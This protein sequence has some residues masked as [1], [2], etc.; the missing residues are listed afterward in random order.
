MRIT[1]AGY[2]FFGLF[3]KTGKLTC[4]KKLCPCNKLTLLKLCLGRF[5]KW[6]NRARFSFHKRIRP[7]LWHLELLKLWPTLNCKKDS[8]KLKDLRPIY[9]QK[10]SR[11]F[12]R[13]LKK[14]NKKPM[15]QK[16]LKIFLE[17]YTW[18]QSPVQ[19]K[20]NEKSSI[21]FQKFELTKEKNT[22]KNSLWSL[23]HDEQVKK[24]K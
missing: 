4:L 14:K 5:Q 12:F 22:G 21:K 19:S 20:N 15:I 10:P 24:P 9:E 17:A 13:F 18:Y 16:G 7:G 23:R 8:V 11:W 2:V 3:M 6:L 1:T